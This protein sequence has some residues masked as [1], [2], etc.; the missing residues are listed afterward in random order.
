MAKTKHHTKGVNKNKTKK[1]HK[2]PC[3]ALVKSANTFNSFEK[4]Y[5]QSDI[6]KN[7]KQ[8]IGINKEDKS[9]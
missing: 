5:E 1:V 6:F 8:G 7:K 9:G 4:E 2:E 3:D